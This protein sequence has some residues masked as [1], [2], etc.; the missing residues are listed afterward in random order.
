MK[1][2]ISGTKIKEN[3]YGW[4][5]LLPALFCLVVV[6]WSPIV[7]G[8]IRS[9]Y[10]TRGYE[11]TGFVGLRNYRDVLSDTLFLTT[12]KNSVMYVVW[13][14]V[15]G[16]IPPLL[17]AI[18]LNEVRFFKRGFRLIT[19]IPYL[20]PMVVTTLIF[21][22]MYMPGESGFLNAVLSTVGIP[23]QEWLQNPNMTIP[24]IVVAMTFTGAPGTAVIYLAALQNIS[25]DLYEA[26]VIDGASIWKR[27]R[28]ITLPS[29][30]GTLLLMTARQIIGVFQVMQEP[31]LMTGGGPDNASVTI[32]L[33]AYNYAFTYMKVSKS[34]AL[35]T[36]A[37]I[38]LAVLTVVYFRV[39]KKIKE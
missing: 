19:Y 2:N 18:L 28:S 27:L 24:L 30:A 3:S 8:V 25:T 26:A 23:P 12:L 21:T 39:E 17:I 11:T 31:L 34:L 36:C 15:I 29:I 13:S 5:L 16:F 7:S 22:Y 32:N 1:F 35:G 9:F 4:L 10:E 37:F 33:T 14:L 20:A 38:F 6:K